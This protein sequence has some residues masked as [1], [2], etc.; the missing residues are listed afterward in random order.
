MYLCQLIW[1]KLSFVLSS[2]H[3]PFIETYVRSNGRRVLMDHESRFW[4]CC[5]IDI[6]ARVGSFHNLSYYNKRTNQIILYVYMSWIFWVKSLNF[7]QNEGCCRLSY[8]NKWNL[9]YLEQCCHVHLG[10]YGNEKFYVAI[11]SR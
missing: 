4:I 9:L 2:L 1:R 3:Q 8:F 11:N 6:N 10:L 5:C 7:Y